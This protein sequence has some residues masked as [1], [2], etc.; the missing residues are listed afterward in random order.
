MDNAVPV[1]GCSWEDVESALRRGW[2][3][4]PVW[5]VRGAEGQPGECACPK[6]PDCKEAGKH[7]AV[8]GGLLSAVGVENGG[9][10]QAAEWW[11]DGAEPRNLG[12]RTG[13]VSDLLVVDVD[14]RGGGA[15]SFDNWEEATGLVSWPGG[16]RV[17]TGR[18]GSEAV[19]AAGHWYL[20]WSAEWLRLGREVRSKA[21]LLPGIDVRADGGY[22][23]G[24]GS[25]HVAGGRY[26]WAPGWGGRELPR[27]DEDFLGWLRDTRGGRRAPGAGVIGAEGAR[28]RRVG[29]AGNT[30]RQI[31]AASVVP[32]GGRDEYF[33][34]LA[35]RLRLSRVGW[36]RA[37]AEV[38]KEWERTEQPPGDEFTWESALGKLERV[39]ETVPDGGMPQLHS[40]GEVADA[41][42]EQSPSVSDPV[43]IAVSLVEAGTVSAPET[44]DPVQEG[45]ILTSQ[46]EG[47]E[48]NHDTGNGLRYVRLFGGRA[49]Y[50]R[51][52]GQWFLWD[53][54]D[55]VW[56]IDKVGRALEW[57]KEVV[58]DIRAEAE[59][60]RMSG[61]SDAAGKWFKWAHTTSSMAKRKTLLES[62]SVEEGI[63]T[64]VDELDAGRWLMALRG[65]QTVDL[66]NGVV[67]ASRPEDLATRC[68]G[69]SWD[70]VAVVGPQGWR[71]GVWESH[72]LRMVK[73]DQE[74]AAWLRRM[75]GYC[76]TGSVAEQSMAI[77]HGNG[78]N[79][80]N[81][82]METLCSVWGDYAIK[83]QAGI[84]T[85]AD[86]EHPVGLYGLRGAR[87]V[88]VDEVGRSRIN[89]TRLKDITGGAVM[90][91]R[92]IGQSWVEFEMQGKVW[93]AANSLPAIR[94]SSHGMWR[95]IRNVPLYGQLGKDGWIR[96]NGFAERLQR[97]CRGEVMAWALA[98][99]E[100]WRVTGLGTYPEMERM[101]AQYRDEEDM[102]GL[103]IRECLIVEPP[104]LHPE[105]GEWTDQRALYR[106]Y[107]LWCALS[108]DRRDKVLNYS[109]FGRELRKAL[110]GVK[111]ER[112]REGSE[113]VQRVYGVKVKGMN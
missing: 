58:G 4:F 48:G 78:E 3:I 24:V 23:L 97:D 54:T 81:V 79:G 8:A 55:R 32:A 36:E 76:L 52:M 11:G 104:S 63:R 59:M 72:V 30:F 112:G 44:L 98:G 57:T 93:V 42:Q 94:D 38:R 35:F 29:A 39:W 53:D 27:A 90:R 18:G 28:G 56:K 95:R 13:S 101:S 66:E 14:I 83:A 85:A 87:L 68:A 15:D 41:P 61:D 109:Y 47:G 1:R 113:R 40:R 7:P 88:F 33:N 62:S 43:S 9:G 86:D 74:A 2:K 67:R 64:E 45:E 84:L 73:G 100:E 96:E 82:F 71:G 46:G 89:E 77:M 51:E 60:A 105:G 20:R 50:V 34:G 108:Q 25:A 31:R 19:G 16:G 5:G 6:G 111:T 26:Q 65:G 75:A 91:A 102:F 22:V 99:L 107:T 10:F 69:V 49:R 103:F 12:V 70:E 80:K 110:P 17:F 21:G 106:A 92:D 37:V